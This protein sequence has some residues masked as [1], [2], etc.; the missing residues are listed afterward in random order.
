MTISKQREWRRTAVT[1]NWPRTTNFCYPNNFPAMNLLND[2]VTSLSNAPQL[3]DT[4]NSVLDMGVLPTPL[5]R[6][7]IRHQ[8]TGVLAKET[9]NGDEETMF[10]TKM[11][12]LTKAICMH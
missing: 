10:A 5:L 11:Y 8:L 6:A 3:R 7:G 12:V 9:G 1:G 2:A 4:L